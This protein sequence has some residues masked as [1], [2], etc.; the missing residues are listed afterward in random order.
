M[1]ANNLPDETSFKNACKTSKNA[2]FI[3]YPSREIIHLNK[4]I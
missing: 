2:E 4:T 1:L 3:T